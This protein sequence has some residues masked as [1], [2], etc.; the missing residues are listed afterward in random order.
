MKAKVEAVE[1]FKQY[2]Q[3]NTLAQMYL[4]AGLDSIP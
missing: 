4:Q 3:E 2:I 1:N